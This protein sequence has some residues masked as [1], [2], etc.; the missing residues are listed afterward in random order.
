MF[1]KS[2]MLRVIIP[3]LSI[4]L[5]LSPSLYLFNSYVNRGIGPI[6]SFIPSPLVTTMP[7]R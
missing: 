2:I 3:D 4:S 5:S 6:S 1:V 7:K